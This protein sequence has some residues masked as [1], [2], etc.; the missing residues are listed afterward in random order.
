MDGGRDS[1]R[2]DAGLEDSSRPDGLSP[3]AGP[4]PD[5]GLGTCDRASCDDSNP[6]TLEM[7]AGDMCVNT[8]VDFDHDGYASNMFD[9]SCGDCSDSEGDAH[10]GQTRWFGSTHR[11][12]S[13]D[14][15]GFDWNCNGSE[16]QQY[17]TRMG[18]CSGTSCS[19]STGWQG[20]VP[21]CGARAAWSR[22][23]GD[24]TISV[25]ESNRLQG[26]H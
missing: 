19:V 8:L 4:F 26:C 17:T 14:P 13:A 10:P 6:C 20:G 12:G 11:A 15:E 3:D 16:E 9:R 25:V 7:C 1:G 24:C 23:N 21:A 5:A 18:S 2:R 22:C